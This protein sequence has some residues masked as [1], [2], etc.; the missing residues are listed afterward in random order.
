M[1]YSITPTWLCHC[2]I[3]TRYQVYTSRLFEIQKNA[4]WTRKEGEGPGEEERYGQKKIEQSKCQGSRHVGT[5]VENLSAREEISSPLGKFAKAAYSETF[6]SRR[7]DTEE[8]SW[9]TDARAS[10]VKAASWIRREILFFVSVNGSMV[11]I[12][13]RDRRVTR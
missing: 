13:Y 8:R 12:V 11:F 4:G 5:L 9:H 3:A 6:Q 2:F 7:V 10:P 1:F